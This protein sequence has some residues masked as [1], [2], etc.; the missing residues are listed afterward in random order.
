MD[1]ILRL[2]QA[3]AFD[4][5]MGAKRM[6]S[7]ETKHLHTGLGLRPDTFYS[8][9]EEKAEAWS[10][11]AEL[12]GGSEREVDLQNAG[13]QEDSVNGRTHSEIKEDRGFKSRG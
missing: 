8:L 13:K 4:T 11:R 9:A 6:V 10:S 12:L 5:Q 7:G 3:S 2:P 1:P